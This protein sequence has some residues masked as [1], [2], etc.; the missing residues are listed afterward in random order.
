[1]WSRSQ[2]PPGVPTSSS[3]L[4]GFNAILK[5]YTNRRAKSLNEFLPLLKRILCDESN[6]AHAEV[7]FQNKPS[8][9]RKII[10]KA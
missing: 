5:T 2:V 6:K 10:E 3:P 8:H 7:P 4:E 1:M 9:D